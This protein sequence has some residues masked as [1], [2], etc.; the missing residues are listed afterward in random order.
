MTS[1]AP[2]DEDLVPA[3]V[4]E[5]YRMLA[6]TSPPFMPSPLPLVAATYYT[7]GGCWN[8]ALALHDQLADSSI[9]VLRRNG[10]PRHA[11]FVLVAIAGDG[12]GPRAVRLARTGLDDSAVVPASSPFD[13]L[14]RT[15][16]GT[17]LVALV[18]RQDFR[19]AALRAAQFIVETT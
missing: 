11:C 1:H 7:T 17:D 4:I 15:P 8:L 12:F 13:E 10:L 9:E 5:Q 19:D 2:S 14:A 18:G 16:S 6:A 3:A